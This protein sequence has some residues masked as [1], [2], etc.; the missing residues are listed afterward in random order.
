VEDG[1]LLDRVDLEGVSVFKLFT[2][3]DQALLI[4]RDS[5]LVLNLGLDILNVVSWF[6]SKGNVLACDSLIEDLHTTSK[7]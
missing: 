1:V 7:G 3:E 4:G 2:R 6:N 5:F